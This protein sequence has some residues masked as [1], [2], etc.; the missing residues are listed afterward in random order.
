MKYLIDTNVLSE[1]VKKKP[2]IQVLDWFRDLP[3]SSLHLSVL[4]LGELRK[5]VDQMPLSKRRQG[6]VNWLENDLKNWF[7]K[8]ILS[9]DV[10]LAESWGS[11]LAKADRPLPAIDSLI[12]ATAVWH[13]CILVTRNVKDFK[14]FLGLEVLNPFDEA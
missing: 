12:A 10:A 3:D 13:G 5:G 7:G 8:R 2:N 4:T 6:L 11:M 14:G 1:T 9:I